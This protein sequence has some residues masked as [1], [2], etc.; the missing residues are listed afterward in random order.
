MI[1]ESE[2]RFGFKKKQPKLKVLKNN[3]NSDY[4]FKNLL[5][6][7]YGI[8]CD[9]RISKD[10]KYELKRKLFGITSLIKTQWIIQH[11]IKSLF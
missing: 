1:T 2:Y 7:Q 8:L 9:N 10:K 6:T 4:D 5:R 3:E 11:Y